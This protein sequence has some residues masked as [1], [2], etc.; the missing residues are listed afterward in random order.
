MKKEVSKKK[1]E[2]TLLHA[3]FAYINAILYNFV[4][5]VVRFSPNAI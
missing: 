5:F 4:R 3:T 1:Y 2:S